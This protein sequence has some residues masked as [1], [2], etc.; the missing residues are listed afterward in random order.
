LTE[1][2]MAL[3]KFGG[4]QV[5]QTWSP[6]TWSLVAAAGIALLTGA[7]SDAS[8]SQPPAGDNANPGANGMEGRGNGGGGMEGPSMGSSGSTPTAPGNSDAEPAPSTTASVSTSVEPL[9]PARAS[10]RDP[11]SSFVTQD[12]YDSEREVVHFD[13]ERTAMLAEGS[14][15]SVSGWATDG[16]ELRWNQ[17]GVAFRVR[18]GTEEGAR[19]AYFTEAGNGTICNLEIEGPD[20][21]RIFA[22]SQVPPQ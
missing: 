5:S 13:V 12:V 11:D 7:C 21:L 18:F 8:E 22:T 17:S 9:N 4:R 20:T 15:D 3:C 14:T 1:D 19:R 2:V 16:N 10:F 6:Q